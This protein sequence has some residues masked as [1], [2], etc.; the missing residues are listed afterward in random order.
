MPSD[1]R[2]AA[3]ASPSSPE[4]SGTAELAATSG[5]A[6]RRAA[7]AFAGA[8]TALAESVFHSPQWGHWPCHLA[9]CPRQASQTK[10]V[11]VRATVG[12]NLRKGLEEKA[13]PGML[14]RDLGHR[15]AA[16]LL[17]TSP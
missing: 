8:E 7:P 14:A 17:K 3:G 16:N 10:A 13:S 15:S 4:P 5:R 9:V 1:Q 12:G 6:A 2:A 11:A